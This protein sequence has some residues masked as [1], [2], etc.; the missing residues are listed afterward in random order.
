MLNYQRVSRKIADW[1]TC[2][3]FFGSMPGRSGGLHNRP[4]SSSLQLPSWCQPQDPLNPLETCGNTILC[5]EHGWFQAHFWRNLCIP[6]RCSE[7]N[8]RWNAVHSSFGKEACYLKGNLRCWKPGIFR[9]HFRAIRI[10]KSTWCWSL[11]TERAAQMIPGQDNCREKVPLS[12]RSPD[13][14]RIAYTTYG[15]KMMEMCI[16]MDS[17]IIC[18]E[19]ELARYSQHIAGVGQNCFG[20]IW[21][22]STDLMTTSWAVGTR[23]HCWL[24][25]SKIFVRQLWRCACHSQNFFPVTLVDSFAQEEFKKHVPYRIWLKH[26]RT[27]LANTIVVP[28]SFHICNALF[29]FLQCLPSFGWRFNTS[30]RVSDPAVGHAAEGEGTNMHILETAD[31]LAGSLMAWEDLRYFLKLC[32]HEKCHHNVGLSEKNWKEAPKPTVVNHYP[33]YIQL[34]S[35]IPIQGR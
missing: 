13:G 12:D 16:L 19:V 14:D 31:F 22:I 1:W 9:F 6:A 34:S 5:K 11:V 32:F 10:S 8:V 25:K 18:I 30:P 27:G 26:V 3:F 4:S 17:H 23:P 28:I 2:S 29:K 33:N 20:E 15:W 24:G 35:I 21:E 7:T